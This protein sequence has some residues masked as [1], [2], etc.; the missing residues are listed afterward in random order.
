MHEQFLEETKNDSQEDF[1]ELLYLFSSTLKQLQTFQKD[2]EKQKKHILSFETLSKTAKEYEKEYQKII[3]ELEKIQN[4]LRFSRR[5]APQNDISSKQKKYY[6]L[7]RSWQ[8]LIAGLITSTDWQSPTFNHSLRSLAGRQEGEIV[9]NYNDYKRDQHLDA[10]M[11]AKR[12]RKEY[13]DAIFKF[14]IPTYLTN[15]GMAALTTIL[16]F[17]EMEKK[18]TGPI[19]LGASS[20]FQNKELI[21][22]L[23]LGVTEMHEH[24]TEKI[25]KFIEEKNPSV[26]FFDSLCNSFD[27][28]IPNLRN[29]LEML[30]RVQHDMENPKDVYI[31]IDNTCLAASFQPLQLLGKFPKH[32]HM[33]VFESMNKYHQFGMDRTMG[34]VIYGFGKDM[35]KLF[36]ARQ[37]SG[38][39]LSDVSC[40]LLPT[41]NRKLLEKRLKRHERNAKDI[42]ESLTTYIQNNSQSPLKGIVYP[43]L[44]SHEA[45]EWAKHLSFQ[46]SFFTFVWKTKYDTIRS[47]KRFVEN[48]LKEAKKHQIQIVEGTSFGMNTSRIYL[49]AR[50]TKY[51]KPFVRFSVGTENSVEIEKIKTVLIEAIKKL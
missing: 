31:I 28:A 23:F 17:L 2:I 4:T 20:Y 30:K 10:K 42:I 26:L 13:I 44:A 8:S 46:G 18:I 32:I 6:D 11:Y 29:I 40:Y 24:D 22:K 37:H 45:K 50:N 41:P 48:V 33:I 1:E 43:T 21:K 14:T 16:N 34:G 12:F 15:S 49:T 3:K 9:G 35:N 27:I 5:F 7:Y 25:K 36:F 38:T 51:G 47:Y 39:I 19:L